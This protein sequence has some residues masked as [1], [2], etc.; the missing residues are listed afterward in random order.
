MCEQ[1]RD[2]HLKNPEYKNHEVVLYQQRQQQLPVEKCKIH[3]TK[4]IDL[5]CVDCQLLLCSKCSTQGDHRRHEIIDLET[6]Y[7]DKMALYLEEISKVDKY[8]LPTSQDLQKE[9]KSDA[10]EIKTIMDNLRTAIKANGESLKSLVDTVVSENM[11]EADNIEQSLLEKLLSQDAMFDDYI[12]YLHDI[13]KEFSGYVSSSKL[14]NIIP[15]LSEK[16]LEIRPIPETTK[17]VTP[18]FIAGEYS[19]DDVAILLGKINLKDTKAEMRKIKP[20]EIV[21]PS[22]SVKSTSQQ[23]KQERH[24]KLM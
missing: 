14:S 6:V 2:E 19:K 4:D 9:I 5:L 8:F 17:P 13:L 24:K 15:K 22:P 20:M 11:Q 3:P 10:I 21:S 1:C 7:A 16:F 23:K 18:V 12:S